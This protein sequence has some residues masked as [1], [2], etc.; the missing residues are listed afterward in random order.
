MKSTVKPI[1]GAV[2]HL[3]ALFFVGVAATAIMAALTAAGAGLLV[4]LGIGLIPLAL[5]LLFL[6]GIARM[7]EARVAGLFG[8]D[9]PPHPY[10]RSPRTDWLRVPHTVWLQAK[11]S[12]NWIGALHFTIMFVLAS[13][14]IGLL[15]T[16]FSALTVLIGS[17]R[18]PQREFWILIFGPMSGAGA[19]IAAVIAIL[20]ALALLAALG[21]AHREISR[22]MLVPSREAQLV[23]Q[24]NVASH[25][26]NEAINAAEI[27]RTRIERDL[28]DGVQP[29]LVSVGMTLGMAKN[30]MAT[31][32][33]AAAALI[34]EAHLSTKAAITELRQLARGI[35]PAVL[36]DRGLDAA[37]SALA[38]RSHVPVL[39][40][41]QV[42]G[43]CSKPT[44]A[45]LYFVIAE[46]L[47]NAAKHSHAR[48]VRVTVRERDGG[49]V[50][51]RVEDDGTGGAVR[52]PGGGIDGI[53][54][55]IAAVGGSF[56]LTSPVG[57]PTTVEVSVPCAS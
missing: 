41:V 18:F 42:S 10:A 14:A 17:A 32:P 40:D 36:D 5:A 2:A 21:V 56:S 37:L 22:S 16:I 35:H 55:R 45:A 49:R 33:E 31:D 7:E 19:T 24:A 52:T 15:G 11:D 51:A 38:A 30:K 46:A 39:L 27:E 28:H 8:F 47:T 9:V 29:R 44:E 1:A 25:R 50:W 3:W 57:G 43:R 12:R 6:A 13:V 20:V 53:A 23:A 34:E 48:Q 26:R 54:G 4:V